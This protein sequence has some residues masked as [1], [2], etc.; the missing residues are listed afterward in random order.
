MKFIEDYLTEL[1]GVDVCDVRLHYAAPT[2]IIASYS[3]ADAEYTAYRGG[4]ETI[5]VTVSF[6]AFS[7]DLPHRKGSLLMESKQTTYSNVSD[8]TYICVIGEETNKLF[9]YALGKEE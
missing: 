3:F 2:N 4:R 6:S 7:H 8:Y 5:V 9:E 1:F